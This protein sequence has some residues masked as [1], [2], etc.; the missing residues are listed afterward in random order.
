MK[1]KRSRKRIVIESKIISRKRLRKNKYF[2]PLRNT[3]VQVYKSQVHNICATSDP[4]QL[5]INTRK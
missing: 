2:T 5:F 3:Q 1:T 4:A